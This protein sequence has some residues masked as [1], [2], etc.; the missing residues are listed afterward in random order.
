MKALITGASSGL[1]RDMARALAK[2][3]ASLLLA[4]RRE[5]PMERLKAELCKDFPVSVEIFPCDLRSAENCAA[6]RQWAGRDVD[7]L[8]NNAGFGVCGLFAETEL[9]AELAMLDVDVRAMH[10]LMKLFLRDFKEQGRGHILNVASSAAFLPGPRMAAYYAAKSYILR[11][12][13]AVYEELRREKSPVCVSVLCPGPVRTEFSGVANVRF[14]VRGLESGCVAEYAVRKMLS[15][16][17]VIVPG[18]SMKAAH[19]FERFLPD[20]ALLRCCWHMQ[21]SGRD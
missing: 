5:E 14:A 6:L 8:I 21:K 17:L 7:V 16:K 10:I 2:R 12:T 20:K 1:G 15:G 9:S 4:A 13:E 19:L 18:A 3:G 11:L